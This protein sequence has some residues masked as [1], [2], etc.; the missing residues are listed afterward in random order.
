M[1]YVAYWGGITQPYHSTLCDVK[2][3][4]VRLMRL[5]FREYVPQCVLY[6]RNVIDVTKSF[7]TVTN[8]YHYIKHNNLPD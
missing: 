8:R 7:N 6:R 5:K 1:Y 2:T 4:I 3:V